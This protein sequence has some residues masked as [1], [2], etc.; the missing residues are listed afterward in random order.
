M[1]VHFLSATPEWGTPQWLFDALHR[2]FHFTLDVCATPEN[3]KCGGANRTF[4]DGDVML[5]DLPRMI[6]LELEVV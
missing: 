3:A 2:R 6:C 1:S 5:L 4:K